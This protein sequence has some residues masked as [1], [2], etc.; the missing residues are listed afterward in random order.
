MGAV[1]ILGGTFDPVHYGH[2]RLAQEVADGFGLARIRF[3]PCGN[4]PHREQPVAPAQHRV[5][6]TRLALAGNPVFDLDE[7]EIRRAG[8]S[9][10]V[11]TLTELRAELGEKTPL[12]LIVGTDAFLGL[13]TWHEWRRL[14][15][16]AH[17]VVAHRAGEFDEGAM[18]E[19]LHKEYAAR[20]QD[21][22]ACADAP[23]GAIATF[24]MTALDISASRIRR[25]IARGTNTRYLLPDAV[26][27]YIQ[28]HKLYLEADGTR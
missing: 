10:S 19:A 24:A 4:P 11:D 28:R 13:A 26:L 2:L 3:I 9:Y 1:G 17:V 12:C 7:R 27:D 20:R 21:G 14:F 8:P 15:G 18:P 25:D 6:M 5:E 22:I 23:A 16:L